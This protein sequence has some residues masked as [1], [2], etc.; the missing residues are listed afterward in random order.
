MTV[1]DVFKQSRRLRVRLREK[2]GKRHPMPCHIIT[3]YLDGAGVR[4]DPKGRLFR[5]I[6]RGTG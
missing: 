5:T 3:A 6:G 1:E 2:G 4:G